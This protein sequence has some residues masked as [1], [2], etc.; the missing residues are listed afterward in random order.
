MGRFGAT[1]LG[2]QGVL[3]AAAVIALL[4]TGEAVADEAGVPTE[5]SVRIV[6]GIVGGGGRVV[7]VVVV[8]VV[9]DVV[10]GAAVVAGAM[11]VTDA[12][13]SGAAEAPSPPVL[14]PVIADEQPTSA[15]T[16]NTTPHPIIAFR[17]SSIATA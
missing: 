12:S 5:A 3:A 10:V 2:R 8:V 6:S 7:V 16:P 17:R 14:P 13:A 11:V 15:A 9:V 4:A 1:G